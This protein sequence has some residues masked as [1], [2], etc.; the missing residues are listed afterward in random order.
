MP[1]RAFARA[2]IAV[3]HRL[4]GVG[5]RR[6]RSAAT[7]RHQGCEQAEPIQGAKGLGRRGISKVGTCIRCGGCWGCKAAEGKPFAAPAREGF[8]SNRL[9]WEGRL[10]EAPKSGPGIKESATT[11]LAGA[12]KALC[13]TG[14]R[15]SRVRS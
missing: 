10:P 1:R 13:T 15:G 11:L 5:T 8:G 14:L 2:D 4:D 9:G 7:K 3:I 12:S 6:S